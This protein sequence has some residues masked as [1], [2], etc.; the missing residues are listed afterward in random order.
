MGSGTYGIVFKGIDMTNNEAIALKKI[1]MEM[2]TEGIPYSALREITILKKLSHPNIIN[3]LDVIPSIGKLHLVMEF[4]DQDMNDLLESLPV[5]VFL[6][7]IDVKWFLYQL[8]AGTEHCHSRFLMHRDLK[9]QNLLI[10]KDKQLKIA[11]FGL[12]RAF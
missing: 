3:L 8:I 2:E 6:S 4:C 9:P 7:P 10:N 12:A 1:N 5:G 11:D